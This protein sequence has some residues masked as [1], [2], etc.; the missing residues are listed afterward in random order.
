MQEQKHLT[1]VRIP[2]DLHRA[3]AARAK[4]QRRSLNGEILVAIQEHVARLS[5]QAFT[6]YQA[7]DDQTYP[8]RRL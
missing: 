7:L 3:L 8:A 1:T 4:D 5:E 2:A 6:D